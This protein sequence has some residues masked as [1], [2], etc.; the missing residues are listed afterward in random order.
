MPKRPR[1][2]N[3]L[4][5]AIVDIATGEAEDAVSG[6]KRT[7]SARGRAGGQKGGVSRAARLSS[8]QLSEIA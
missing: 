1:D 5:K 8:E 3:Q 2:V 4:A 7:R 6:K